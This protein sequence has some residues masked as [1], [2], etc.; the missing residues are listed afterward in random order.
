MNKYFLMLIISVVI[1]SVSQ[2][3]LKVSA[4]EK[5]ASLLKEYL[6]RRVIAGYA[7]MVLS[8][9]LTIYGMSGVAFKNAPLI[10][11]LGYP[12]VILLSVLFLKEKM[13]R[14]R[15]LGT[16]LILAGVV[17]FYL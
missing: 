17:I 11:S 12:I 14:R 16:C 7:L 2:I 4:N 9:L 1:A 6:N 3:I 5:H 8:T 10:E 15:I 13:T